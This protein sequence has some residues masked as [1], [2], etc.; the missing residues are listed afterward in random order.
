MAT[1]RGWNKDIHIKLLSQRRMHW[2]GLAPQTSPTKKKSLAR[3]CTSNFYRREQCINEACTSN[4]FGKEEY[5]DKGLHLKLLPR[6]KECITRAFTS[7]FFI[8]EKNVLSSNKN[9]WM[10]RLP[11]NKGFILTI[12]IANINYR[13]LHYLTTQGALEVTLLHKLVDSQQRIK[14]VAVNLCLQFLEFDSLWMQSLVI[15][16]LLDLSW[17]HLREINNRLDLFLEEICKLMLEAYTIDYYLCYSMN[18]TWS[19][20]KV[21]T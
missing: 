8:S 19:L 18:Y 2:Q 12:L 10:L 6:I 1:P 14:S 21:Q 9:N 20:F 5:I 16:M 3:A 13:W 4:F 11:L 15:F 7:N 17:K